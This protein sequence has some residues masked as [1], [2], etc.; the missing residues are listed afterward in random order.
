MKHGNQG[1]R[2]DLE[3]LEGRRRAMLNGLRHARMF[4]DEERR[5]GKETQRAQGRFGK[6]RFK[7]RSDTKEALMSVEDL[8]NYILDSRAYYL[9]I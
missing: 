1:Y 9:T 2:R 8:G 3:T 5:R 6:G 7:G 4:T